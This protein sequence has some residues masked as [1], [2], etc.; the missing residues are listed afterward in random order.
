MSI[1]YDKA[2]LKTRAELY[3][4]KNSTI[5]AHELG[6]GTQGIIFR[7]KHNTALKVHGQEDGYI[8]EKSVYR[9]LLE[10]N[11]QSIRGFSIPRIL[12]W[13]DILLAFEMSIV[14]VPCVLDF[15]G[16]YVDAPPIHMCRDDIW[17]EQKSEEFGGNWEEAQA[18]IRELEHRADIW[19]VDVNCGNIKFPSM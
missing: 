10:R 15:G 14:P 9:R 6:F 11:I 1:T 18:I 4:S 3:C 16:V 13:D 12:D 17:L 2:K 7:T 19:L 8:R 5:L